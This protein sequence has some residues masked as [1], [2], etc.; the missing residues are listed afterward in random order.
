MRHPSPEDNI[1]VVTATDNARRWGTLPD[2]APIPAS[3]EG[4][5]LTE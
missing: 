4:A 3:T 5:G 1:R 2:T